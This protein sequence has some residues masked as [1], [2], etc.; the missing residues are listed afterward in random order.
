M[1][2]FSLQ[3]SSVLGQVW[4]LYLVLGVLAFTGLGLLSWEIVQLRQI[5]TKG[6][7]KTR[8]AQNYALQLSSEVHKLA[9]LNNQYWLFKREST[10]LLAEGVWKERI[11]PYQETL[12]N[13][14]YD[15]EETRLSEKIS[16]IRQQL[17]ALEAIW[18]KGLQKDTRLDKIE[19]EFD[20]QVENIQKSITSLFVDKQVNFQSGSNALNAMREYIF[21]TFL[22]SLS[23][24]VIIGMVYILSVVRY[25]F[26][27][28][29]RVNDHLNGYTKGNLQGTLKSKL[30]ELEPITQTLNNVEGVFSRLKNLAIEVGSGKF[31]TEIRPFGGKGEI[32][33][34]V[35]QM[36]LS[37]KK[38]VQETNERNW[39]NEGFAEIGDLLRVYS[40]NPDFYE[41]LIAN[42]V[43]YI[44]VTQGGVFAINSEK[45]L[46]RMRASYAFSRQK[47]IIKEIEIGEGLVGRVWREKDIVHLTDV[48]YDYA[49][50]SSGLGGA[51]PKSI[52]VAPLITDNEVVGI[53]EF[54]SLAAFEPRQ[55]NFIQRIAESIA[56][57]IVRIQIDEETKRLL[58][59]SQAL[60][61]KLQEQE[62]ETRQSLEEATTAQEL[63][64]RNSYQM[65][66]Q[67]QALDEVFMMMDFDVQGNF[68]RINQNV[69]KVSNYHPTELMNQHFS[70]LLGAKATDTKVLADWQNVLEGNVLS[71]EFTRFNKAGQKYWMYEV[72]YPLYDAKGRMIKISSIGYEITKQKEQERLIHEQLK[73][74]QMSKRDVV[75]RIREVEAKANNK[76]QRLQSELQEQL[77]EKDRIIKELK[78]I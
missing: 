28:I 77:A 2:F 34:E 1:R 57:T 52:L 45:T 67:L 40:R 75:N 22:F 41:I 58:D 56:A 7:L 12:K 11:Y 70:L 44:G 43:K 42:I 68:I 4:R 59:E 76:L 20:A 64:E 16:K 19:K 8:E 72:I 53:L 65:E 71:G 36:R 55:I 46:M 47:Y 74:L 54:A 27:E 78:G 63:M 50:I 5:T 17:Q 60:A 26:K 31:D 21:Y 14:I 23:C 24:I 13:I 32:G 39:F 18:K 51:Q 48:P 66:R 38:I 30:Y 61:F 6:L 15:F 25:L 62:E 37:L 69:L 3:R 73:E 29:R 49:E 33:N 10:M 9:Y 35:T